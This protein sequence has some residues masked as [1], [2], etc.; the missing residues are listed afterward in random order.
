[1]DEYTE[2]RYRIILGRDIL[3]ALYLEIMFPEYVIKLYVGPY[4]G[5]TA[6]IVY[7]ANH[8]FKPLYNKWKITPKKGFMNFFVDW[9]FESEKHYGTLGLGNNT[10]VYFWLQEVKNNCVHDHTQC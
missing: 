9:C 2:I 5:Y 3:M 1:M 8:G 7:L 10:P 6:P 4:N